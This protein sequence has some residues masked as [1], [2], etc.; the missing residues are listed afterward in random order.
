MRLSFIAL[1]MLLA[2]ALSAQ[3][4]PE[5]F[6]KCGY[7]SDALHG[8][9]TSSGEKYDKTKLTCAH[10]SLP[11]GT[12]IR[13][14]RLDNNKSVEVRVN[15]RGPYVDGY[16]TDISRKAAE[17]IDLIKAGVAKVKI[18]VVEPLKDPEFTPVDPGSKDGSFDQSPDGATPE[19]DASG[20]AL[21]LSKTQKQ[22]TARPVSNQTA[23]VI[24]KAVYSVKVSQ[25]EVSGFG[26]QVANLNNAK[27]AMEEMNKL[28]KTTPDQVLLMVE[29]DNTT[30][31]KIAYKVLI[32]PFADKASAEKKQREIAQKGYAKAFIIDMNNL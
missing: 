6:G 5:E 28:Q 10:K 27:N 30:G 24:T 13:V 16:V 18:E 20:K 7:Y 8:R 26:I 22:A 3:K 23:P 15:D 2:F 1:Y 21:L 9:N 29:T 17:E 31:E 11:F 19:E 32:G 25:P 4:P 14:T 12:I